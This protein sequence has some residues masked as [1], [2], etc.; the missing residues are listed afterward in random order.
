MTPHNGAFRLELLDGRQVAVELTVVG[1]TVVCCGKACYEAHPSLGQVLRISLEDAEG[2]EI[3][4]S[5]AEFEG[6]VCVDESCGCRYLLKL[7]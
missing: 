6:T 4:I 3:V 2:Q 5:E 7:D 1:R